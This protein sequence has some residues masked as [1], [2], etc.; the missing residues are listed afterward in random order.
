VLWALEP[1]FNGNLY[2]N[3]SS[4]QKASKIRRIEVL[5]RSSCPDLLQKTLTSN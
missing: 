4:R 5:V 1:I 2:R 3:H